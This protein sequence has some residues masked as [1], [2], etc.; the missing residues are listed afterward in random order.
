MWLVADA[1]CTNT[2]LAARPSFRLQQ[3]HEGL[4]VMR[5]WSPYLA[6]HAV[7]TLQCVLVAVESTG[8]ISDAS[9]DS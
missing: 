5:D 2:A 6:Q 8:R 4:L 3:W 9:P 1:Y 7:L